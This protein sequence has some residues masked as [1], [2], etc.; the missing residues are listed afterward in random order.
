MPKVTS[1][2]FSPETSPGVFK[3]EKTGRG[4]LHSNWKDGVEPVGPFSLFYSIFSVFIMIG[5][6]IDAWC[7]AFFDFRKVCV[8]VR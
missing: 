6:S 2:F 4:P 1:A 5:R 8:P 7:A 3:S